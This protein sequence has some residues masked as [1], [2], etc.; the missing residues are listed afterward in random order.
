MQEPW[1]LYLALLLH[2]AGRAA[3][4]NSHADEST[5][6]A[7]AVCRR[8]QIKGESRRLL[9]FLVDNHLLLYQVGTGK[10]LED[11]KVIEDFCAIVRTKQNLDALLVM[12]VADSKGTSEQS[13]TGYKEA[14][15]RQLYH[16][17][18]RCLN[19][20]A[21]FMKIAQAPLDQLKQ[22]VLKE[23]GA[24]YERE[25]DAHFRL[26]PRA[27]FNFRRP[28]VIADHIEQVRA[29]FVRLVDGKTDES[30]LPVLQWVHHADQGHSVLVV[31]GWD[32]HL[33]LARIAGALAAENINIL[34]AKLYRRGDFVVL[35]TFRVCTTNLAAVTS[36]RAIQ[37]IEKAVNEAFGTE[38]F[39]FDQRIRARKKTALMPAEVVSEIQQRV[40][41]N[42]GISEEHTVIELQAVDRIGLLYDVFMTIG[43]LGH[44]VT[45]ARINT[46]LGTAIDTI[47]IQDQS[48]KKITDHETLLK[49]HEALQAAVLDAERSAA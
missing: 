6:L 37:R 7:D 25:T 43:R 8:L 41:I 5:V 11:P 19:A 45:H 47:Y 24:G 9:L 26:M 18:V 10:S 23:L 38:A 28:R 4:K 2:D 39:D 44:N 13:W 16:E 1:I 15:V 49:L 34:S 31:T 14:S 29:F 27:Y 42:N 36:E 33:L 3:N 22:E 21:D 12:T 20:P 30:L 32:R 40:M 48:A 46:E 35:D 17:A